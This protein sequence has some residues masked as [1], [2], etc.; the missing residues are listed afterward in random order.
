MIHFSHINHFHPTGQLGNISLNKPI[1]LIKI[2]NHMS[3]T[4]HK[5][6]PCHFSLN[7]LMNISRTKRRK[8]LQK[9]L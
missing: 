1:E 5:S 7:S 8:L 2:N 6:R 4:D 3:I 9:S